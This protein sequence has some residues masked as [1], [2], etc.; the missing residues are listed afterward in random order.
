[1]PLC[2][3]AHAHALEF[4]EPASVL[5]RYATS[6][7][8]GS[9]GTNASGA[10]CVAVGRRVWRGQGMWPGHVATVMAAR[11]ARTRRRCDV[12]GSICGTGTMDPGA[13]RFTQED[14]IGLA[15]GLNLYGF[16]G[17]NP[18]N[19]FGLCPSCIGAPLV[20]L[21]GGPSR[22]SPD[23]TTPGRTRR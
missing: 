19:P 21:P 14:P 4:D 12:V 3:V 13:G 5:K 18:V 16:A 15:G 17:S 10:T 11:R 7:G 6:S 8:R 2:I 22:S 20:S 9:Y 1:M 23:A